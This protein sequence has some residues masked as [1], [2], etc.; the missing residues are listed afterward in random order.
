MWIEGVPHAV[1][2]TYTRGTAVPIEL[3][4]QIVYVEIDHVGLGA[5]RAAPHRVQQDRPGENLSRTLDQGG[6]ER[7][8]LGR[9]LYPLP[10]APNLVSYRVER[11]V[12]GREDHF[13]GLLLGWPP[14]QRAYAGQELGEGEGL[15]EV[16][17]GPSVQPLDPVLDLGAGGEHE[18]R[19]VDLR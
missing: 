7:E 15:G 19:N 9:Q 18:N 11:D 8:L 3:L 14:G 1:N 17:V 6:E 12:A 13:F 10:P 5:N 16:I 4:A 2:G